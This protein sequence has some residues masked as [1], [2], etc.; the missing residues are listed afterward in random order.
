MKITSQS[1]ERFQRH[2]T[3]KAGKD[4]PAVVRQSNTRTCRAFAPGSNGAGRQ[5]YLAYFIWGGPVNCDLP[6]SATASRKPFS[7]ANEAE[8]SLAT[9]NIN[10]T[11][12]VRE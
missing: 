7:T 2:L 12:W 4:K 1:I 9:P 6:A 11:S 8:W 3:S 5:N 10:G